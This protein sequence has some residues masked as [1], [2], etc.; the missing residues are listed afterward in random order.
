MAGSGGR[1]WPTKLTS[2]VACC[3]SLSLCSNFERSM[4]NSMTSLTILRLQNKTTFARCLSRDSFTCLYAKMRSLLSRMALLKFF[5]FSF[6]IR[7]S[8]YS[9][10]FT[11]LDLISSMTSIYRR[12]LL[13]CSVKISITLSH[14]MWPWCSLTQCSQR[15][16][17]CSMQKC[18]PFSSEWKPMHSLLSFAS[19]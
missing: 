13:K 6:L 4:V 15:K 18:V 9:K 3:N 14:P 16:Q 8:C 10:F 5:S 2:D 12:H 11:N 7:P 1:Y 17:S 19:S